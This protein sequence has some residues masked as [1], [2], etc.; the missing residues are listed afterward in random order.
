MLVLKL[1]EYVYLLKNVRMYVNIGGPIHHLDS[2]MINKV[3]AKEERKK[4]DRTSHDHNKFRSC[5]RRRKSY[6]HE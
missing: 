5:D 4:S 2:V 3:T 1:A 6:C